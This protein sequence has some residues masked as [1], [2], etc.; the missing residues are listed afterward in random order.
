MME[1]STVIMQYRPTSKQ[2]LSC[3]LLLKVNLGS[4]D[5]AF[6]INILYN[7]TQMTGGV[8][9]RRSGQPWLLSGK[10]V[11]TFF[12]YKFTYKYTWRQ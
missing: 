10:N 4:K 3:E 7:T 1:A 12:L 5:V 9:G 11:N 8:P 2:L 6:V